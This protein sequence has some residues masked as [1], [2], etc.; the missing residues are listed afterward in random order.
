MRVT[1]FTDYKDYVRRA[2]ALLPKK[3][4]GQITKM[5]TETGIHQSLLSQVFRGSRD[6]SETQA[7]SIAQ[8]F[9]LNQ[10]ETFYFL[11]LVQRARATNPY[12]LELLDK[13]LK[14]IRDKESRAAQAN[15]SD[16]HLSLSDRTE[17]YSNWLHVAVLTALSIKSRRGLR[18]IASSLKVSERRALESLNFLIRAGLAEKKGNS[19][20][21]LSM[22]SHLEKNSPLV[23]LHH[24]NWRLKAMERFKEREASDFYLTAPFSVSKKDLPQVKAVLEKAFEDI[25]EI[26][27]NADA[28]Q[29]ACLNID[30]FPF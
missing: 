15:R 14:A 8:F 12:L 10:E 27:K 19:Y 18:E 6:L 20:N 26:V 22:A 24:T 16:T 3:G 29:T 1:E 4:Y 28:E 9:R 23:S 25:V 7:F 13:E 2:L 21:P 5:A 17:F 11:L 30:L